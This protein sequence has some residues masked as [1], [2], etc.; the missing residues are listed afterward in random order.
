MQKELN[1]HPQA[2]DIADVVMLALEDTYGVSKADLFGKSRDSSIVLGRLIAATVLV[3]RFSIPRY[4]VGNLLGRS[5]IEVRR[6]LWRVEYGLTKPPRVQSIRAHV[7]DRE[8]Q[9]Q[10]IEEWVDRVIERVNHYVPSEYL[11]AS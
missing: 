6:Q 3:R 8:K 7:V 2:Y 4:A 5:N 9:Q 11:R 1:Y 10:A